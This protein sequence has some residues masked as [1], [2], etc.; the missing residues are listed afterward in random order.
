[1]LSRLRTRESR[2]W[3]AVINGEILRI[4]I[5]RSIL[6]GGNQSLI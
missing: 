3:E 5:L 6:M 2:F 1:M 4:F